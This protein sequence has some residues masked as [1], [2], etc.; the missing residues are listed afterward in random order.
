MKVIIRFGI[1]W[2]CKLFSDVDGW[3]QR[4][5]NC[6]NAIGNNYETI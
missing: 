3:L 6:L 2:V 4:H 5:K 1:I